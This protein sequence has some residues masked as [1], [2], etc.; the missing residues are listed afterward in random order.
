MPLSGG[1]GPAIPTDVFLSPL[2]GHRHHVS[3]ASR[4]DALQRLED[5]ETSVRRALQT[6]ERQLHLARN[7]SE[8][9]V[10][11]LLSTAEQEVEL[12]LAEL[13]G[14]RPEAGGSSQAL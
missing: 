9:D 14:V 1:R 12:A 3:D 7:G 6:I 2:T 4:E 10:R 11:D 5:A 8:E 13:G